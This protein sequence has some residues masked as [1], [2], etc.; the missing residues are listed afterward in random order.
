[1]QGPPLAKLWNHPSLVRSAETP[2][3]CSGL[4]GKGSELVAGQIQAQHGWNFGLPGAPFFPGHRGSLLHPDGR[5]R[6]IPEEKGQKQGRIVA[7]TQILTWADQP[8]L[9]PN[10]GVMVPSLA[11]LILFP[12][13]QNGSHVPFQIFMGIQ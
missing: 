10:C 1:M 6:K 2:L 5:S 8:L 11:S 4:P 3:G 13:L 9:L 12:P 7:R